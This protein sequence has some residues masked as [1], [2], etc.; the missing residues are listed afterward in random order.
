MLVAV[1]IYDTLAK[2]TVE[3]INAFKNKFETVLL[4]HA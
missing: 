4:L 2:E 1:E 3:T